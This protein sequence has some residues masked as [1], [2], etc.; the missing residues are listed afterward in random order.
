M[1]KIIKYHKKK[2]KREKKVYRKNIT[3]N[4]TK[5]KNDMPKNRKNKPFYWFY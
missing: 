2:K 1:K 5:N 3:E 4:R